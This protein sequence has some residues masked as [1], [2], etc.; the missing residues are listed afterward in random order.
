M[1]RGRQEIVIKIRREET[2]KELKERKY[3]E[4]EK[5]NTKQKKIY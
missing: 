3:K 5:K 4:K 1:D 2:D